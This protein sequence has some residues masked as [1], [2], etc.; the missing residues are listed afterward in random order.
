MR[1]RPLLRPGPERRGAMGRPRPGLRGGLLRRAPDPGVVRDPPP[2]GRRP[3]GRAAC[4]A[5]DPSRQEGRRECAP[6]GGYAGSRVA[7]AVAQGPSRRPGGRSAGVMGDRRDRGRRGDRVPGR[8]GDRPRDGRAPPRRRRIVPPA[9]HRPVD[10]GRVPVAG[11]RLHP[12]PGAG[13]LPA[14]RRHLPARRHPAVLQRVPGPVRRPALPRSGR[15]YRSSRPAARWARRVVRRPSSR[16]H[17]SRCPPS[18][19]SPCAASPI[20]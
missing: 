13:Q 3:H 11:R 18:A 10:A 15:V 5:R 7:R 9:Q 20:R 2:G 16:P 14:D 17:S 19:T 6:G 4:R 12:V 1:R 8:L